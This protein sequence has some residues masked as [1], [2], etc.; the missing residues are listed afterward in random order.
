[1]LR[2]HAH[3]KVSRPG[4]AGISDLLT[5]RFDSIQERLIR[6]AALGAL[7][8]MGAPWEIQGRPESRRLGTLRQRRFSA[9]CIKDNAVEF[10]G[11]R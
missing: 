5:H 11:Q 2:W 7:A 3:L 1:M 10:R 6:R 8:L 4:Q 9:P